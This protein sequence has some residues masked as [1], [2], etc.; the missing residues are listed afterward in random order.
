MDA[1]EK[2]RIPKQ[3]MKEQEP[4]V[5][6]KNFHEVPLGFTV[7]NAKMEAN[8]CLQCKKPGC[9]P[10][11]PVNIQIPDFIKLIKLLQ[12]MLLGF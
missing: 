11:C 8:R 9:V 7:E 1:K 10:C 2:M 3:T 6:V 5:R 12:S 4:S